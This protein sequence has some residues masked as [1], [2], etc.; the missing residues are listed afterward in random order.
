[1]RP[2]RVGL[3]GNI[4][5]GKSIV[6]RR[7]EAHGAAIVDADALARRATR[8]PEVLARI[9]RELGPELV[10]E[11]ELDR[12]ATA[13]LVFADPD[14]RARLN[15]I[16]HPW[17]RRASDARVA[18][19]AASPAPPRVVVLDIPLLYEN[20]LEVGLDAVIVVDAPLAQ[21]IERVVRR[22]ELSAAEVEARDAA[23]MPLPA[24]V[25]RA[26][27]V[28]DN[29]GPEDRLDEAVEALWREL[30]ARATRLG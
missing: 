14:A 6:A 26:D 13:R 17:V 11:G 2:L 21:R 18:A 19:L 20:G 3:T 10:V 16:V 15:A 27:Y 9:A 22:G 4:G 7:L 30:T 29:A 5:S 12:A 1:M 8:D 23:Q 25:A 28:V 24:K